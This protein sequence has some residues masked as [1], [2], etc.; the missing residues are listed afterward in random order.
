MDVLSCRRSRIYIYTEYR[1]S[2]IFGCAWKLGIPWYAPNLWHIYPV[3]YLGVPENWV[4]HGMPPI[5]G[6]Y[7]Q[8]DI[9]VCPKIGYSMVCPQSMALIYPVW[10]L[11]VPENWVFHGMPPI[12]GIYTQCDIWVCLK[13]GYSMVCPQSMAYIP[14]VIFGCAWKLGIP[15][16]APN[17]WHIYPVWY[18]GVPENLVFHGMPPIYG[19]YTQCD[20]WVCLKIGYS[21]VYP[22]HQTPIV[23]NVDQSICRINFPYHEDS[24]FR[25]V[26]ICTIL[27]IY[28]YI[29]IYIYVCVCITLK[30]FE[31]IS[32]T[33]TSYKLSQLSLFKALLRDLLKKTASY[34]P[35]I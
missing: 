24:V 7:T 2:A 11:G 28:I 19:I 3:R 34:D 17:L 5:Y 10:Y 18:L 15:W 4:F 25:P 30:C 29:Y 14:S 35:F 21:M 26:D 16:Y 20:I 23:G 32:L 33:T 8:C 27:H 31:Q 12:Y 22:Q 13:I 9:W 6:I 1:T